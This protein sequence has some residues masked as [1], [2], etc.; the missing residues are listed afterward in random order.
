M[1][2]CVGIIILACSKTVK[3]KTRN[4]FKTEITIRPCDDDDSTTTTD[5]NPVKFLYLRRGT[6]Y[7]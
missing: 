1:R 2:V 4:Q 3:A 6:I 7:I 5:G